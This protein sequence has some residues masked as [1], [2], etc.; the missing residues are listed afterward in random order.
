MLNSKSEKLDSGLVKYVEAHRFL[1]FLRHPLLV[2]PL[3]LDAASQESPYNG[4]IN[5]LIRVRSKKLA[6]LENQRDYRAALLLVERPFRLEYALKY[7]PHVTTD[8]YWECVSWVWMDSEAP[9]RANE[10]IWRTLFTGRGGNPSL[11]DQDFQALPEVITVYRGGNALSLSWTTDR[12]KAEWFADRFGNDESVWMG[13]VEK[14]HI[15]HAENGRGESELVIDPYHVQEIVNLRESAC[16][17]R[18]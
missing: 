9:C 5:E 17:E 6:E 2:I 1:S 15:L 14:R 18:I 16:E 3:N 13:T 4:M 11:T 8:E 10:W 12:D 7:L